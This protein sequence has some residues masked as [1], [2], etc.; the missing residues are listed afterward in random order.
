MLNKII[1]AAIQNSTAP[2]L[3]FRPILAFP[4]FGLTHVFDFQKETQS[5]FQVK[6]SGQRLIRFRPIIVGFIL[7]DQLIL[8]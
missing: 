5:H 6:F 1:S 3:D 7:D 4:K 2:R 8:L